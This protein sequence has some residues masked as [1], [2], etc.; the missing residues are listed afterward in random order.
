MRFLKDNKFV[1]VMILAS[2]LAFTSMSGTAMADDFKGGDRA[3][4]RAAKR[5]KWAKM[6][7]AERKA[8]INKRV[9]KRVAK[10]KKELSLSDAQAKKVKAIL[11]KKATKMMEIRKAHKGDRKAAKPKLKALKQSTKKALKGVLNAKQ[12]KL[13]KAK[14][15]KHRAKKM[16]K[17]VSKRIDRMDKAVQLS[18]EQKEDIKDV[19]EGAMKKRMAIMKKHKG[20]RDAAKPELKKLRKSTKSSIKAM[21]TDDQ[22]KKFKAMRKARRAERGERRRGL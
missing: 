7:P 8:A 3:E 21:L 14:M 11:T 2:A 1:K 13:F 10:M 12:Q 4:K 17:R 22:V 9:D 19:M 5:A 20:D 16:N 6:T 15:Q 18:D